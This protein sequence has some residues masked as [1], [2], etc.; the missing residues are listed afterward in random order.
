MPVTATSITLRYKKMF[1]KY[2]ID[3]CDH[4]YMLLA[5]ESKCDISFAPSRLDFGH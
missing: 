5:T 3:E 4:F 2:T 1:L